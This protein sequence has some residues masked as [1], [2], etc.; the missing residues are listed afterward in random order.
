MAGKASDPWHDVPHEVLLCNFGGP[1]QASEVEPFLKRLFEDPFIIRSP[2]M[3]AAV[4]RYL[5]RRISKKRAPLIGAEYAKIGYSPINKYTDVQARLLEAQLREIRPQ[6]TVRV[7][8]RYTAP[9]AADVI[10]RIDWHKARVFVLSLYPH[11]CHSTTVSSYRDL[12]LALSAAGIVDPPTT[13][14][15]SWWHLPE[16]LDYGT[17]ELVATLKQAAAAHPGQ[18]VTVL[19]SAHGI[20]QRYHERGDPYVNEIKA[21]FSALRQRVR[22]AMQSSD[23]GAFDKLIQW[24]LS[25]QS[26]VG[27]VEWV[28]PY[29]DTEV[30]RLANSG[31]VLVMVPVS[32]TSDHIETLFEMDHTYR[33]LALDAGFLGYFR[34]KTPNGDARLATC[35]SSILRQ[36]GY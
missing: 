19:F 17:D 15:Y 34:V 8:N 27:P 18:R 5:A 23:D 28:K 3:P 13:R 31:G 33:Q 6:S 26:R 16:Y 4:R 22:A 1:T 21:H 29:T 30:T 10:K 36:A 20:P 14:I 11:L 9:H 35:L 2:F 7:V 25:F 12:D 32:F 24:Q